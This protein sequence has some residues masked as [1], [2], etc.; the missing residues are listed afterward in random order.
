MSITVQVESREVLEALS[1]LRQSVEKL[2]PVMVDIGD[3]FY[4]LPKLNTQEPSCL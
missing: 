1:Q 3:T 4:P 2:R